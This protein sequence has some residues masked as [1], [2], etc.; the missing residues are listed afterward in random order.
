MRECGSKG[1]PIRNA[2]E[3]RWKAWSDDRAADGNAG[4][5][6]GRSNRS[7]ARIHGSERAGTNGSQ[8]ESVLGACIRFPWSSWRFD[9]DAVVGWRWAVPV[10][11]AVGEGPVYLAKSGKRYSR[12]DASAIVDAVGRDR[13]ASSDKDTHA[14]GNRLTRLHTGTL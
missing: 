12:S 13:L 8:R 10:C 11:E 7:A 6:R 3:Q 1:R 14:R 4:L 9:Q 2:S 5:D